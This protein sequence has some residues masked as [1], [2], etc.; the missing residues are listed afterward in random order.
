[1]SRIKGMYVDNS[2]CVRVKEDESEWFR[3]NNGVKQGCIISPWLF[4]IYMD[5]VMELKMGMRRRG[6]SFLEHGRKWRVLGL[7]YVDEL[8]LCSESEED[9]RVMVEWFAEVCRRRGLR[10]NAGKSKVMAEWRGGIRV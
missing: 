1:M 2:A 8:V 6:V 3:I 9:L 5:G 4:N 7:L 10:V